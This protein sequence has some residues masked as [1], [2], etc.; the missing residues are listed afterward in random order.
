MDRFKKHS[1]VLLALTLALV[2]FLTACGSDN[3]DG[4]TN[5]NNGNG[6]GVSETV[7]DRMLVVGTFAD[8]VRLD[9]SFSNDGASN[10]VNTQIFEALV[11]HD[12][13]MNIEPWLAESWERLDDYSIEFRLREDVYF[14][15]GTHLTADDVYFSLVRAT[16][17]A[18]AMPILGDIDPNGLEIIDAYTIIVRTYEPFAPLLAS[19]AHTTAFIISREAYEYHGE[20]FE[21]NPIGTGPFIFE[22]WDH[23]ERVNLTRNE[24]YWGTTPEVSGIEFRVIVDEFARVT[25]LE[26]GEIDISWP[27]TIASVSTIE[28]NDNLQ[29]LQR[30]SLA[31]SFITLNLQREELFGD[32]RVRQALNYAVDLD[33]IIETVL[34]G[35][36]QPAQG[37]MGVNI[38]GASDNIEL[39]PF[40]P[41]RAR[42]LLAEAGFEDGFEATIYITPNNTERA[43]AEV[44]SAQLRNIGI[45]LEIQQLELSTF[46]EHLDQGNHDMAVTGW[47]AVTGDP[48][49]AVFPL[50]HSSQHGSPGN[51]T[52]F[53]NAEADALMERARATF[54]DEERAAYYAQIQQ[55]IVDE[56]PWIFL[57]NGQALA[58]M[59]THV[60]GY[61][62]RLNGQQTMRDVR[63]VD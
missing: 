50:L 26:T 53:V 12:V 45:A 24:N 7:E 14:H 27:I 61:T 59:G 31:T 47:T 34:E 40:N 3:D 35:L 23:G 25:A 15:N 30:Y 10:I 13:D 5:A 32:V 33:L 39:Y 55:L 36:A 17:S 63:F 52:F 9:P 46:F 21:E 48:D 18:T 1:V 37:P 60:E 11:T 19:L 54:D 29:L 8:P 41:E 62:I 57:H 28:G 16:E 2:L 49:Y 38:P 4:D 58:A 43:I 42:E 56:A 44:V 22:S 51:R 6:E 20:Y